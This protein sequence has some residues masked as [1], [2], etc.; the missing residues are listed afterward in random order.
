MT[1]TRKMGGPDAMY[2]VNA[3]ESLLPTEDAL[4]ASRERCLHN[5]KVL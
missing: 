1:E 3:L 5:F 2:D 4:Q